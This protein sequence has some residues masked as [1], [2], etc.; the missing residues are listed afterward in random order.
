ME[1][2]GVGV[3]PKISVR[4]ET[5]GSKTIEVLGGDKE[6]EIPIINEDYQ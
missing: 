1:G 5:R 6:V 3:N 2:E 4:E